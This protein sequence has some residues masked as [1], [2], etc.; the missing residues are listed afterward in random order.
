M[1][2]AIKRAA[3]YVRVSTDHQ[4]FENQIRELGQVDQ[5]PAEPVYGSRHGEP[6]ASVLGGGTAAFTWAA[7]VPL[8]RGSRRSRGRLIGQIHQPLGASA[9][10]PAGDR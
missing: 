5:R 6:V 9:P 4:S 10:L 3:L 7:N 2:K 8:C 1:S